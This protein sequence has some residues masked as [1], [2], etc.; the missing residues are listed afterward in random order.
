MIVYVLLFDIVNLRCNTGSI[1][2]SR[3][4]K[5]F[6]LTKYMYCASWN[7]HLLLRCTHLEESVRITKIKQIKLINDLNCIKFCIKFI[8]KD[9]LITMQCILG[10]EHCNMWS[11]DVLKYFHCFKARYEKKPLQATRIVWP[12]DWLHCYVYYFRVDKLKLAQ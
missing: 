1:L 7:N 12:Y 10:L 8:F 9:V 2:N 11:F 6:K 4:S 3:K 5:L